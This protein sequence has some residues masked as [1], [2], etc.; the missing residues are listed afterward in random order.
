M[1]SESPGGSSES[2]GGKKRSNESRD[3]FY[4]ERSPSGESLAASPDL[5]GEGLSVGP[6]KEGKTRGA[7]NHKRQRSWGGN[8]GDQE[9]AAGMPLSLV[10]CRTTCRYISPDPVPESAEF[11]IVSLDGKVWEL[12]ASSAEETALWVKAI[13]EQIKKIYSENISHKRMVGVS[14]RFCGCG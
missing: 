13:E 9:S 2:I 10:W 4:L 11:Q 14:L 3:S 7:G 1:L 8:K 5:W 12:E 6:G